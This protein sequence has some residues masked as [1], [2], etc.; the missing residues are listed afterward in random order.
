M[1]F[2]VTKGH[3]DFAYLKPIKH[4]LS[5]ATHQYTHFCAKYDKYY[6]KNLF[7]SLL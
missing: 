1:Q 7:L 2:S 3:Y 6:N 5:A 4:S